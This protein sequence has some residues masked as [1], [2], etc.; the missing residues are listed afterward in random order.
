MSNELD[1]I[2]HWLIKFRNKAFAYDVNFCGIFLHLDDFRSYPSWSSARGQLLF[3]TTLQRPRHTAVAK[4]IEKKRNSDESSMPFSGR[5][6]TRNLLLWHLKTR[7]PTYCVLLDPFEQ[8][9]AFYEGNKPLGLYQGQIGR[10]GWVKFWLCA[11]VRFVENCVE[12]HGPVKLISEQYVR[13][14]CFPSWNIVYF[15]YAVF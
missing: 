7:P 4:C 1:Q 3:I 9:F 8:C 11:C 6:P 5:R 13:H 2:F 12:T 10:L 15:T 14:F